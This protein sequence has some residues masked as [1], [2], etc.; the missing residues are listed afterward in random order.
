MGIGE[1]LSQFDEGHCDGIGIIL[2]KEGNVYLVGVSIDVCRDPETGEL[3]PFAR[4]I[5]DRLDTYTEV[6]PSGTGVR[7]FACLAS[8]PGTKTYSDEHKL[9]I[10]GEER[11]FAM[12]GW[13]LEGAPWADECRQDE[14]QLVYD[15]FVKATKPMSTVGG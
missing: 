11:F 9:E 10:V 13:H 12:T 15:E 7:C 3:T 5:V 14:V 8:L 1:A 2:G 6:S 4:H